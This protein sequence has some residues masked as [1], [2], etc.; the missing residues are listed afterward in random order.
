VEVGYAAGVNWTMSL[1]PAARRLVL[2]LGALTLTLACARLNPAFDERDTFA[3]GDSDDGDSDDGD[4]DGKDSDSDSA[5]SNDGDPGDGDPGDGDPGDG[6]GDPGDGDGDPGDGD[7]DPGDGDG[8]PTSCVAAPIF[9]A[10]P[11]FLTPHVTYLEPSNAPNFLDAPYRCHLLVVCKADQEVCDGIQPYV[12]KVYSGGEVFPGV[13]AMSGSPLQMR[14][15]P[16]GED[17]FGATLDLDPSQFVGIEH[18][19]ENQDFSILGVRL[20][21]LTDYDVPLYIAE[22]GS[23]FWNIELSDPAALWI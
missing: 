3:D 21:C 22:D 20:P 12:A 11:A 8:D 13:D 16:G 5:D 7:G 2:A 18:V 1:E 9:D 4:S 6:D 10:Y 23:T 15:H 19:T 17:C 14:F